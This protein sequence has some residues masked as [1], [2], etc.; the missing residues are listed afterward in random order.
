[1]DFPVCRTARHENDGEDRGRQTRG[2][3][4]RIFSFDEALGSQSYAEVQ[5]LMNASNAAPRSSEIAFQ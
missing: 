4:M 2:V 5:E 3:L 1:M